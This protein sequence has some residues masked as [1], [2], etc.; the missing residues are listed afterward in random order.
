[1]LTV[2]AVCIHSYESRGVCMYV[3]AYVYMKKSLT[4][5]MLT[6]CTQYFVGVSVLVQMSMCISYCDA[7]IIALE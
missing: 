3:F 2:A 1:M 5:S 4:T 6:S 7:M